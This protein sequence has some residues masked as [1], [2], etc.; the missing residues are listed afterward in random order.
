MPQYLS[1]HYRYA[2]LPPFTAIFANP[3]EEI[4]NDLHATAAQAFWIGTSYLLTSAIFQPIIVSLSDLFGR[5]QL[6]FISISLFTLGTIICASAMNITQLLVGRCIQ[7]I[8]GGG[9][10]TLAQVI[11]TDIIPLRQRPTFIGVIQGAWAVGTVTGPLFGGAIAQHTTWRWIFYL[12]F[13]ICGAGLIMTLLVVKLKA[14][15]TFTPQLFLEFDWI[16][17]FLFVSST[18]SFLIGLVWGGSEFPWDSWHTQVPIVFGALGVVATVV[19]EIY[20]AASPFLPLST[21]RN[22]SSVMAYFGAF[23]QGLLVSIN[24]FS[25]NFEYVADGACS[26]FACSTTYRST[27]K[28]S[29]TSLPS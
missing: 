6:L 19:W 23:V 28:W 7:G 13:P 11:L 12:N 24:I 21:F 5:K 4:S 1:Q 3:T 9:I 25:P 10:V 2:V 27:F 18:C 22:V 29:R 14:P 15:R 20:G 16:G 26:C 17:G 8:G